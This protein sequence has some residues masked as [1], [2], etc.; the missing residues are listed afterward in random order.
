MLKPNYINMLFN[1]NYFLSSDLNIF[2][3]ALSEKRYK[4]KI[5]S[6]KEN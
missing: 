5:K 3:K 4:L 6:L 2:L 1:N